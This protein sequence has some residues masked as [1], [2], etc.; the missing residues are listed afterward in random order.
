MVR[1]HRG[2]LFLLLAALFWS[3]GGVLIKSIS[4]NP[5]AIAGTRSGIATLV[6]LLYLRRPRLTFSPAQMGGALAYAGTVVLFV[7]ANKLTT[8][9]NAI[10][11][12]YSAPIY[13]ILLAGPLLHEKP[14]RGDFLAIGTV[15]MGIILFFMD[16]LEWGSFLGNLVAI[17]SGWMFALL[18]IFLRLQKDASPF[19]S[20]LLGNIIAALIGFPFMW[21][22]FPKVQDLILL[23]LL[24]IFQIGI[25]YLFY[26]E[27][28]KT[29]TAFEAC[30]IPIVEPIL[31][32][33]W[34]L[35][36]LKEKPGYFALFGGGV[37]LL[38]VLWW[39]LRPN[40]VSLAVEEHPQKA[41]QKK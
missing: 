10:I 33:I 30:F 23:A 35:L 38:A 36:F 14:K 34:V 7:V 20:V 21:D 18:A 31:N 25:S 40:Q 27:A 37:I 4:W 5:L 13:V 3:T 24:G 29:A 11:L 16:K 9:A 2:T 17:G 8:A 15:F 41:S 6:F 28:I 39:T 22:A 12:Q 32:P 26:V 19:E 1:A